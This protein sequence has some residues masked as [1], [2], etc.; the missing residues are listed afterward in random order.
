MNFVSSK[1]ANNVN[2]TLQVFF[3]IM[4]RRFYDLKNKNANS[5]SSSCKQT[6]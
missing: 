1:Y 5:Q 4:N 6:L 3:E 2:P